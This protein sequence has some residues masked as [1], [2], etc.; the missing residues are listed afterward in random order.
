MKK[1]TNKKLTAYV[2]AALMAGSAMLGT[3]FGASSAEAAVKVNPIAGI[4]DDFIKGADVS[5]IPELERL[6]GKFYDNGVEKDCLTILQEKGINWVRVRIWN[7]PYSYGP[8]GNGGGVTDEKK[9]LEVAKRAKALG[10]KVLVDFHYSDWWADPGKQ[11]PPKAWE[12][13][14]AKQLAKDVYNY[15]AKVMKDFN[16]AGVT[17]D[18]VQIGNELN[19]GML[20]PVCKTDTPEGYKALA[21]AIAQGLKAV[22]DNDPNHQVTRMVHLANGN[23]N[24]L[25][26]SFFDELI[27][28]NGVNDF[29]VIGFS[30]YPFWH[31][32][33]E[34]LSYN[35]NDMVDRYGKDVIVVETAY[36][37]TNEQ[38][39]AQK[40]CAGPTEEAIAGY[41]ST[42]QGQASGLHDV[43]EH[44]ANVKNGKG[45]GIF[46]WEPDWIPV[47]GA[48][49]KAGEGNEWENLAMFDFQGNAL[50]SLD[51]FKM[52]SDKSKPVVEYKVK[53]IE[54]AL[55]TGSV[56]QPVEMPKKVSVVYENDV[57]KSMPVVWENAEP[58]FDAAGKYTVKGTVNGVA[59]KT[60]IASVDVIKKVNLVKNGTFENGDLSGWTITGDTSAVNTVSSA[61]DARGKS[62]MHYWADKGFKFKATQSFT[63]LKDGKYTVSCWTQGGGGQHYYTLMVQ[64][65]KGEQS[66]VIADTGWNDWHQ[67]VIRDVEVKDGKATIGIDMVANAGNWGSIDDVEFYLQE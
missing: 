28:N 4:S 42:V 13:H 11:Y 15:T 56:G 65:S 18:M 52:V 8:N 33:M 58:V 64:T 62:A 32:S 1:F 35:M 61:G 45:K 53:E 59:G 6:G 3:S 55:V 26:R 9:A 7:D 30:Y 2:M 24:A 34:E 29:D 21:E 5:M 40:N 48:G 31:G 12:N 38:G 63:G 27:V 17:P 50:E 19:N 23:N 66:A 47:E 37:F 67:W 43:M 36:A 51:V 16:A 25:Y 54:A 14:G 22:K 10:M 46:Y 20:W 49:W 39:D 60:A 44:V 57:V 41:K